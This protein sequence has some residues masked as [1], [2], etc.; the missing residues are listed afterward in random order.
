M[1]DIE[2]L[3]EQMHQ[4]GRQQLEKDC[5]PNIK[6]T[7][8]SKNEPSHIWRYAAMVAALAVVAALLLFPMQQKQ[9][10]P[11]MAHNDMPQTVKQQLDKVRH[12]ATHAQTP[13]PQADYAYSETSDGVRV[14]CEDNCNPD[15]VLD[16][17]EQ[18]IKTLE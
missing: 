3:I 6:L 17:M 13:T 7:P 18:V 15:D 11:D 4:A 1:K 16:R 5:N 14:Y 10:M 12:S 2:Q 9:P 8:Q